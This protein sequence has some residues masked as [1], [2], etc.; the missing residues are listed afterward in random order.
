[1][2][3]IGNDDRKLYYRDGFFTYQIDDLLYDGYTLES[4]NNVLD[5]ENRITPF[6]IDPMGSQVL[7]VNDD[8]SRYLLFQENSSDQYVLVSSLYNLPFTNIDV[9][10]LKYPNLTEQELMDPFK[11]WS[12]CH[13]WIKIIF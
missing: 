3:T 6:D 10:V 2:L 12:L 8:I 4:V 5:E 7:A 11:N 9:H 1:M 13:C